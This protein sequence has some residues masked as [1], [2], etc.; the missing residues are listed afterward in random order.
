M[1]DL[2]GLLDHII[3]NKLTKESTLKMLNNQ[4]ISFQGIDGVFVFENNLIKRNL[5]I[6]KIYKGEAVFV[7]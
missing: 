2:L 3:K 1:Y 4:G 7:K 5:N 6:L